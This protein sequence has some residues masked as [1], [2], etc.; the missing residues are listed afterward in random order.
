M[1]R[2]NT[3]SVSYFTAASAVVVCYSLVDRS[4]FSAVRYHLTEA[5]DNAS[6]RSGGGFGG[7]LG[8][9][10]SGCHRQQHC[11]RGRP[12]VA[13][14]LCGTKSDLLVNDVPMAEDSSLKAVGQ[15]SER[16]HGSS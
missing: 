15:N 11:R 10:A 8:R 9:S 3:L 4:S 6:R 16:V 1:E 12:P 14:F 2:Y 13:V 7:H 5:V